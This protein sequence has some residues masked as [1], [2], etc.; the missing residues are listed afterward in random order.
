M[1]TSGAQS[2]AGSSPR[3]T[4]PERTAPDWE[5]EAAR[6]RRR[7]ERE[8]RAR[9]EAEDIAERFTREAMH[10]SLTGLPN[11]ALFLDRLGLSMA[12]ARRLDS[13]LA[14]LFLDLDGFKDVNDRFGHAAGDRLLVEVAA[15]LQTCLRAADTLARL[16]GDEFAIVAEGF[17]GVNDAEAIAGRA[18]EILQRPIVVEGQEIVVGCSIGISL[19]HGPSQAPEDLLHNADLAMYLAKSCGKGHYRLFESSMQAALIARLELAAALRLAVARGE[20]VVYYQPILGLATG[21]MIGTEALVRWR[22]PQRGLLAPDTF[23]PAAEENGAIAAIGQWVLREACRQAKVWD[24]RF[25]GHAPQSIS[26]NVSGR[27]VRSGLVEVV[28]AALD[29]S[30]LDPGRLTLEITETVLLEEGSDA[31][32]YLDD[33]HALGVRLAIDD[34]GVGYSSLVRLRTLPI[35]ILKIDKTFVAEVGHG[36]TNGA[37]VASLIAMAHA[38]GL[39][40]VAEGVETADQLQFLIARGCDAAQ[41]YLF[42]RPI[43]SGAMQQLLSSSGSDVAIGGNWPVA[44]AAKALQ[45]PRL[46]QGTS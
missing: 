5:A 17:S 25:P 45:R 40:V 2:S 1:A 13:L 43:P 35:D 33:L 16:G 29:E 10:D 32:S 19:L 44:A 23:I 15:R 31:S 30:G 41:G 36:T 14:V 12:R 27:Q 6:L 37:L 9:R 4:S 24:E 3:L 11:H 8:R 22:H 38:L 7:Y 39:W 34:F 18:I 42:G 26:V 28:S 21:R 46:T 20:M